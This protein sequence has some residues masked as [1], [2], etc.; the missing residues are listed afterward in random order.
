MY[1]ADERFAEWSPAE[2][3]EYA[4]A[5][6]GTRPG[7][8]APAAVRETLLTIGDQGAADDLLARELARVTP[9]P[10]PGPAQ[11]LRR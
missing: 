5:L 1:H 11:P 6:R 3:A 8:A 9:D 4:A 10:E 7:P 2:R